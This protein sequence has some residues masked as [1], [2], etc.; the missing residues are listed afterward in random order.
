MKSKLSLVILLT[1]ASLTVFAQKPKVENLPLFKHKKVHFGFTLGINSAGYTL[2]RREIDFVTDSLLS[3]DVDNQS[4]FNL[5]IVS[6]LHFNEFFSLRF[7]PSLSFAQRNVNYTFQKIN[8]GVVT[9][10]TLLKPIESTYIEL[11]LLFKY[12]S[13][14]LNNFAAYIVGGGKYVIDLAS[15]EDVDNA[16]QDEPIVKTSSQ[17]IAAEIGVGT[18]FFLPYF[19]FSIEGKMSYGISNILIRDNTIFS[20]PIERILPKMFILSLHFEG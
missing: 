19:K 5:G 15:E 9:T 17:F 11:P 3:I 6:A 13:K 2:D 4:G 12:R 8:E 18:D 20:N 1:I 10:E 14:R 16:T 7:L